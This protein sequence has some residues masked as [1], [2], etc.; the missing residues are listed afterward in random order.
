MN[1]RRLQG[2]ALIVGAVID[3]VA[4]INFDSPVFKV[5][6]IL[7]ALLF[8]F[9][10]PAIESFQHSG[11]LG[12]VGIALLELGA[13]I[14]IV[15]NA[16]AMSGGSNFSS[17]IPFISALAGALGRLLVGGLTFQKRVFAPWVGWA[18]IVEGLLNFLGGVLQI[19]ALAPITG[20]LVPLVGAAALFGY[21]REV[22][23]YASHSMASM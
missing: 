6:F 18:F 2:W 10:V 19:G 13:I 1:I 16:S 8:M 23:Q 11:A 9:G 12:W 17:A 22:M 15:V 21:G 5:L 7:G 4:L 14:A 20:L 3:L